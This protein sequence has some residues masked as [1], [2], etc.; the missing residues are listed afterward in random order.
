MAGRT[1]YLALSWKNRWCAGK[2]Q[3]VSADRPGTTAARN[4]GPGPD[5]WLI[6]IDMRVNLGELDRTGSDAWVRR[7]GLR[8]RTFG[9]GVAE[10]GEGEW[11]GRGKCFEHR[12]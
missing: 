1:V 8:D 2:S 7:M 3:Y 4:I 9:S 10:N 5:L 6:N 12:R 11:N